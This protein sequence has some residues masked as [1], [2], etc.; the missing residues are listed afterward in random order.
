MPFR[1]KPLGDHA[2]ALHLIR[3]PDAPDEMIGIFQV[4][5]LTGIGSARLSIL[6]RAGLFPHRREGSRGRWSRAEV[7]AWVSAHDPQVDGASRQRKAV[8]NS[9]RRSNAVC[10]APAAAVSPRYDLDAKGR[11]PTTSEV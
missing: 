10:N 4:I 11:S 6:M 2:S 8:R 5:G 9:G 3:M 1:R 7:E